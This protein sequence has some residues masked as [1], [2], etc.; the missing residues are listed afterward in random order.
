M[1]EK[2]WSNKDILIGI[3][4]GFIIILAFIIIWVISFKLSDNRDM[5]NII[6]I[7][8]GLVSIVLGVVAI[9]VSTIQSNSSRDLN[10]RMNETIERMDEKINLVQTQMTN[11]D[12]SDIPETLKK[13]FENFEHNVINIITKNAGA[14][15]A[16]KVKNELSE[17]VNKL[18][19]DTSEAVIE[20]Y[21]KWTNN[22]I[23]P[24][25]QI[26]LNQA[27]QQVV[28]RLKKLIKDD[29]EAKK[30]RKIEP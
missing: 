18:N 2:R 24:N 20:S 29:V 6:S 3:L 21:K 28:R 14:D 7:G 8:A 13:D 23:C 22:Y 26:E 12:M 4:I 15:V 25:H 10:G 17:N 30:V 16:E 19:K 11:L 5:V 9:I 27:E 1:N